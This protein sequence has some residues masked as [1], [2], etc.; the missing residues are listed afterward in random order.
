MSTG[1]CLCL[2]R[3]WDGYHRPVAGHQHTFIR[4]QLW[5]LGAHNY[6]TSR[7]GFWGAA[8]SGVHTAD[9]WSPLTLEEAQASFLAFS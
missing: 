2:L 4:L 3:L 5:G 7:A 1:L 9:F 8:P 6:G